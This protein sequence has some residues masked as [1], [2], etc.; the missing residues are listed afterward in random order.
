[1]TDA[2]RKS[3]PALPKWPFPRLWGAR[4]P[5]V[6]VVRLYGAIGRMGPLK[7]GI[8]LENAAPM[9]ARAFG[10]RGISA[11][12]LAINSP[13]GSP[14]Q[15]SLVAG[16][17]RQLA[18]ENEVPV[19]A[20]IEDVGASGGYWLATAADEIYADAG[21]IVGSI[22]VIS[23]GFGFTEAIDKLG[24]ERRVHTAGD[25]KSIL[26]PFQPEKA[27]DV[28][29]LKTIQLELH[30]VFKDH[31]RARRGKKLK[32]PEKELFSGLFWTGKPAL[33]RGLIDGIGDLRSVLRGRFGDK[34]KLPVV[35]PK[36]GF[37]QRRLGMGSSLEAAAAALPD[38]LISAAEE[39]AL[40][41]RFGL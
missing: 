10:M 35:T 21:S 25:N 6:P 40:W 37:L 8:T 26:D 39:R 28:K 16:R 4:K 29:L 11:V 38:A 14:V 5:K 7:G 9:L 24:I 13:G 32:G 12:A 20:F 27:K 2:P 30:D 34:V 1:M 19:F 15:S 33:E 3:F 41:S 23:Q 18:E 22:G 17:I 36:K 31:V